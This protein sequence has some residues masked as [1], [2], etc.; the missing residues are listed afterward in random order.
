MPVFYFI[1]MILYLIK[2]TDNLEKSM[3]LSL[4]DIV[5]LTDYITDAELYKSLFT[6]SVIYK[7]VV[8]EE[9][10]NDIELLRHLIYHQDK[11]VKVSAYEKL[12][13]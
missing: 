8:E 12:S 4:K 5:Y 6:T 9:F 3:T 2:K 10:K 7:I 13:S 1:P 11:F